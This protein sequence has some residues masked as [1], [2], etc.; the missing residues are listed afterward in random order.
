MCVVGASLLLAPLPA[1]ANGPDTDSSRPPADIDLDDGT[2]FDNGSG[3]LVE[4]VAPDGGVVDIPIE[5]ALD[6]TVEVTTAGLLVTE[7]STYGPHLRHDV[8]DTLYAP[9]EGEDT[10]GTAA[11]A[12]S[13]ESPPASQAYVLHSNPLADLIIYLDFTGHT[14]TGT[15]WNESPRPTTFTSVPY[16]PS[17]PAN[18]ESYIVK[19]WEMV[20]ED[21]APFNVDVTTEE[22]SLDDLKRDSVIDGRYGIRIVISPTHDWYGGAGGVAYIN[23][24]R[25]TDGPTEERTPAFVFSNNLAGGYW[26]YVAEAASHEAGHTLGLYHDGIGSLDYYQGHTDDTGTGWAPIMGSGYTK[27]HT[28]WSKGEYPGATQ[29]QDD[30]SILFARLGARDA[31]ALTALDH[32]DSVIGSLARGGISTEF[33]VTVGAGPLSIS[34]D[35]T[36]TNGNLFARAEL[37]DGSTVLAAVTPLRPREWSTTLNANVAQG[38]YTVR[39]TSLDWL[40]PATGFT[41]YGSIG[42]FIL[43]IDGAPYGNSTPTTTTVPA[44]TSTTTTTVPASTSTSTSTTTTTVPAT[45]TTVTLPTP[46]PDEPEGDLLTP[47]APVRLL[48]T[49][50]GTGGASRATAGSTTRVAVSDHTAISATAT[51]AV[52]NVVAVNPSANGYLQITPCLNVPVTNRTAS[53]VFGQGNVIG[54]STIAK[55]D[56]FGDICVFSLVETDIVIDATAWIGPA[57]NSGLHVSTPVR[58]VDTRISVGLDNTLVANT[59]TRVSLAG[60][61]PDGSTAA[62][63]NLTAVGAVGPGYITA[64][65]CSARPPQTASLNFESQAARGNNAIVALDS[66]ESFCIYSSTATDLVIDLTGFFAESGLEFVTADPQ[67]LLDTRFGPMLAA[68]SSIAFKIP[69]APNGAH[70]VAASMVI[71]VVGHTTPGFVTSWSCGKRPLATAVSASPGAAN[72]NGA[73]AKVTNDARSCLFTSGASNLIVDF[74]G[75][76]V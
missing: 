44:S 43:A 28:Q 30:L 54:N 56:E 59:T 18:T 22:P 15:P 58:V 4:L 16:Q 50:F 41:A 31:A 66:H 63:V 12:L 27:S 26:K 47:I 55:L 52:L 42:E 37:L 1:F 35:P 75:W 8:L 67:R 61:V 51:S 40:T 13:Q 62:A 72:A 25:W 5:V 24:M 46:Q 57:G 23:S 74:S 11:A 19:I 21:F 17:D 45:T 32:S 69:A 14:T 73:I 10:G 6:D 38:T 29:T 68:G 20:A 7:P 39:V 49:R 76:W 48:D 70:A 33:S 36:T 34:L 2:T 64:Y 65:P 60:I 9:S 71:T 3:E 53:L